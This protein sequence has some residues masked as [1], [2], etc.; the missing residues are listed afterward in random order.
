MWE[1]DAHH[2]S[3][4]IRNHSLFISLRHTPIIQAEPTSTIYNEVSFS[5]SAFTGQHPCIC[6]SEQRAGPWLFLACLW[7]TILHQ[8]EQSV[9]SYRRGKCH[10]QEITWYFGETCAKGPALEVWLWHGRS[11]WVIYVYIY[12]ITSENMHFFN[13]SLLRYDSSL[14]LI[15]WFL[16][17][18]FAWIK[19]SF[20]FC[21]RRSSLQL[22]SSL[23]RIRWIL[24]NHFISRLLQGSSRCRRIAHKVLW[25]CHWRA[26]FYRSRGSFPG[27]LFERVAKAR[28]A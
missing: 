25:L 28:M 14:S 20:F 21:L 4:I 1:R 15:P 17:I 8:H 26:S 2:S 24:D 22:Q 9:S 18:S 23:C 16:C 6:D 10:E 19:F 5:H 11:K 12:I 13:Y 3:F 7:S 27:R